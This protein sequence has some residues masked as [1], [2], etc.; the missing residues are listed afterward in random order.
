MEIND[1][2][3]EIIQS[4]FNDVYCSKD[5][6]EVS[7]FC[8]Q[9]NHHKRKLVISLSKNLFHCWVCNYKGRASFLIKTYGTTENYNEWR[10]LFGE[11]IYST[12]ISLRDKIT[13][14]N[15]NVIEKSFINLPEENKKLS[16]NVSSLIARH[17]L[18]YLINKRRLNYDLIKMY[19]IRFCE[20]G[21]YRDRIIFPSYDESGHINFFIARAIFEDKL[22]YTYP[23]VSKENMIFNDLF[24]TWERPIILHEGIFDAL[25]VRKNSIPVLGC[26]LSENSQL[27]RKILHYKPEIILWFDNDEAGR[28]GTIKAAKLLMKWGIETYFIDYNK[29]SKK[30]PGEMDKKEINFLLKNKKKFT[31][32]ELLKKVFE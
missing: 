6:T 22:P 12:N 5:K 25:S 20:E 15:S 13:N 14:N 26:S 11:I 23:K 1:K 28:E 18:E 17:A 10:S 7:L 3:L 27:F 30:D 2:K 29:T 19:D 4:I 21:N 8:P 31:E 24:I 32:F 16:S 9:C